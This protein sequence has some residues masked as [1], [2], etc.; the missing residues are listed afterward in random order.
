MTG[1]DDRKRGFYEKYKV[2]RLGGTPGKHD[3]CLFFVLDLDHDPYSVPA[4]RGYATVCRPEFGP[5]ARSLDRIVSDVTTRREV[6]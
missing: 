1:S 5:L 6:R 2:E 4:L 3:H